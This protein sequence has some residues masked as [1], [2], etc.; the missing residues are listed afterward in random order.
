MST[1]C[2]RSRRAK[3]DGQFLRALEKFSNGFFTTLGQAGGQG[4]DKD[5]ML[6]FATGAMQVWIGNQSTETKTAVFEA[7]TSPRGERVI[8]SMVAV[9]LVLGMATDAGGMQAFM[10]CTDNAHAFAAELCRDLGHPESRLV[11]LERARDPVPVRG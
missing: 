1:R 10:R 9:P 6:Q 7:L 2:R 11:G 4:A 8:G 5:E 3:N